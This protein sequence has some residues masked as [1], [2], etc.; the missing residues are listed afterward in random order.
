MPS[1]APTRRGTSPSTSSRA[2]RRNGRAL[3]A[4]LAAVVAAAGCASSEERLAKKLSNDP[5]MLYEGALSSVG[6][7]DAGTARLRLLRAIELDP[8]NARYRRTLAGVEVMRRDW[9]AA[10]A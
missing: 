7:G 8:K 10:L 2:T 3:A 5:E 1:S 9:P 6:S 4:L